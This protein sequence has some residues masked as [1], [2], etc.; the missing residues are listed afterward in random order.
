MATM[1]TDRIS[2]LTL[3]IINSFNRLYKLF[4]DVSG[5]LI[6]QTIARFGLRFARGVVKHL[7]CVVV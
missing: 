2:C 7:L 1:P 4:C 5:Q 6:C 3:F